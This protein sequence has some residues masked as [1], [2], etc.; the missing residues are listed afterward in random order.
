[1]N[2]NTVSLMIYGAAIL[3][4]DMIIIILLLI[5]ASSIIP[6]LFLHNELPQPCTAALLQHLEDP[7]S[8]VY[9]NQKGGTANVSYMEQLG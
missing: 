5:S 4:H 6:R 1:M 8:G 7:F 9:P 2:S 3:N